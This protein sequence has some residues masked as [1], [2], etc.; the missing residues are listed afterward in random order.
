MKSAQSVVIALGSSLDDKHSYLKNSLRFLKT[1]LGE[2]LQKSSIWETDPVGPSNNTFYNAVVLGETSLNPWELLKGLK[3]YEVEIGRDPKAIRWSDREIDL[4][5]IAY[6]ST[7]YI[8]ADLEIPH[9]RY[10]DRL[11]VLEPLRE[12]APNWLDPESGEHIENL[13][14]RATPLRLSKTSLKW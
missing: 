13:I 7:I 4:D 3:K 14:V 12:I 10:I 6:G 8:D 11:F 9:P 1:I 5:I 2:N